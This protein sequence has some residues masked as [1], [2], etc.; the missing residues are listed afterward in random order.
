L[1]ELGVRIAL[2][3]FGTDTVALGYFKQFRFSTLKIDRPIIKNF[4][5]DSQDK[6][7]ISAMISI[8]KSFNMRIVAEGVEI[9]AEAEELFK[10]GCQEIQGNWLTSPVIVEDMTKFLLNSSYDL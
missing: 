4:S 9:K 5:A 6:A 10:L 1:N 8:A 2:D 3:D 7:M